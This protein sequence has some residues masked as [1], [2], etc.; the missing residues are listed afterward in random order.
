MGVVGQDR[1]R[2]ELWGAFCIEGVKERSLEI[3]I[4]GIHMKGPVIYFWISQ[5]ID[6]GI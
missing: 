2:M 4:N 6:K 1:A 3:V 5:L